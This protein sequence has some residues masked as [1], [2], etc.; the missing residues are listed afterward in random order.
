MRRERTGALLILWRAIEHMKKIFFFICFIFVIAA[1]PSFAFTYS[2]TEAQRLA[3]G[4]ITITDHTIAQTVTI[5][6]PNGNETTSPGILSLATGQNAV[7]L[8]SGFDPTLQLSAT[9]LDTTLTGGAD[10]FDLK[11]F[12]FD[13]PIDTLSQTPD[14]SGNMT[15]KIGATLSTRAGRSYAN[16]PYQGTYRLTI[17]INH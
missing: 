17:T 1:Q 13:P 14:G 9:I 2:M 6:A 3:F 10:T 8:L 4:Q 11:D 7:I 12:T 5:D 16:I 15:L